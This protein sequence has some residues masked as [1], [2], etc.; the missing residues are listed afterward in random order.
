MTK[1]KEEDSYAKWEQQNFRS[2]FPLTTYVE[3][4]RRADLWR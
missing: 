4:L 1:L 2:L 3:Y